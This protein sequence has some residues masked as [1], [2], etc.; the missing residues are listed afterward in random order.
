[1]VSARHV[2]LATNGYTD[3]LWPGLRRSVVP[4]FGA[5][6]ASASLPEDAARQV[7][8]GRCVLY[9]SGA[10]TVYYR[11][12]A[13]RRLL[14]GGRGPMR[15]ISS[16]GAIPHLISYA[17]RLW[18]CLGGVGWT[19]A[20]GGRLAMTEDHYPH[21]HQLDHGVLACLGYNGRGVAMST[22][23]GR[24]LARKILTPALPLDMPVTSLRTIG[25]HALW[26]LAVRAVIARGRIAALLGI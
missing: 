16:V 25:M 21:I 22:V 18:P 11:V 26:P 6:A 5:I 15:E 24:Q 3:D 7:M 17:R 12:D 9:E 1:V 20:W 23:M 10:V 2:V 13:G 14:I 19:H 4:V 8:P